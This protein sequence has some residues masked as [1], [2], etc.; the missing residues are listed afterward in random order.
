MIGSLFQLS[1][2]V[3][4]LHVN[5]ISR[6]I[7]STSERDKN[8]QVIDLDGLVRT[9]EN[10]TNLNLN[11]K[12]LNKKFGTRGFYVQH[13]TETPNSFVVPLYSLKYARQIDTIEIP[14]QIFG[15]PVRNDIL[16]RVVVWHLACKRQGTAKTK[17]RGEVRGSNRKLAPQKGLGIARV[18]S[19]KS[20]IRRGG[21]VAHGKVPRD[22][23]YTLPRKVRQLGLRCALSAKFAQNKIFFVDNTDLITHKSKPLAVV[24]KRFKFDSVVICEQQ[25]SHN[26]E[27]AHKNIPNVKYL[28]PSFLSVYDILRHNYLVLHRN[29]LPYLLERCGITSSTQSKNTKITQTDQQTN[30]KEMEL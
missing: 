13:P 5:F 6:R 16:Q 19:K 30:T 29:T 26:L 18:G 12:E 4:K 17:T 25:K 23:S 8:E 21:G 27:L 20:S 9:D 28:E 10:T 22:W 3:P 24:L 7:T 14:P 11:R 15:T 1:R 2:Q